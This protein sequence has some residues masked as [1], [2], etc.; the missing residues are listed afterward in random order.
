MGSASSSRKGA[1]KEVDAAGAEADS[2]M[3]QPSA[4]DAS[5]GG[6][7]DPSNP[8]LAASFPL[9]REPEEAL[10]QEHDEGGELD[11]K[12][13]DGDVVV[14]DLKRHMLQLKHEH[15]EMEEGRLRLQVQQRPMPVADIAPPIPPSP[16]TGTKQR[17]KSLNPKPK[18]ARRMS[19]VAPKDLEALPPFILVN[20]AQII[21]RCCLRLVA[22]F[23]QTCA[24]SNNYACKCARSTTPPN[25]PCSRPREF[26]RFASSSGGNVD[27]MTWVEAALVQ[28]SATNIS[29]P[30][31][32]G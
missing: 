28:P 17:P 16:I 24:I 11:G 3:P 6:V 20:V 7:Q 22:H 2:A 5:A 21:I 12:G 13:E 15:R 14:E 4:S 31:H 25:S 18:A 23:K 26:V 9:L 19:M 1:T 8:Q 29:R 30:A 27:N 10:S 32:S